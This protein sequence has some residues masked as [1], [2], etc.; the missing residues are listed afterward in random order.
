MEEGMVRK[1]THGSLNGKYFDPTGLVEAGMEV[2]NPYPST[3]QPVN[4]SQISGAHLSF[5]KLKP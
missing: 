1:K 5:S 2:A 3:R 4:P